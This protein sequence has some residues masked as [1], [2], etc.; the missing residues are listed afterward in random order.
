SILLI[1][2]VV[3]SATLG[4]FQAVQS[5]GRM[6][7]ALGTITLP[8]Q[9][10]LIA[11][12]W[13]LVPQWGAKGL[14]A[15]YLAGITASLVA[16]AWTASYIARSEKKTACVPDRVNSHADQQMFAADQAGGH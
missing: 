4:W 8:W 1:S 11:A 5:S 15:S 14:A 10:T 12:A 3:E 7:L 13:F 6:W 16:S 2:A 9:G